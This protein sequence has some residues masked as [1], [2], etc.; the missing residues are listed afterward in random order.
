MKTSSGIATVPIS[1]VESIM[2]ATESGKEQALQAKAEM[3]RLKQ[4]I[5]GIETEMDR[6]NSTHTEIADEH[7]VLSTEQLLDY[8][9]EGNVV[10]VRQLIDGGA[11]T[12]VR[13]HNRRTPLMLAAFEGHNEVIGVL[14][15]AG[16]DFEARDVDGWGAL[17]YAV[18]GNRTETV[19]LLIDKGADISNPTVK[20]VAINKGGQDII[21]LLYQEGMNF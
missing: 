5:N 17:T 16:A 15:S 12:E 10:M 13:D 3:E 7:T 2:Y 6:F 21:E 1:R 20:T 8:A 9:K 11:D 18:Y 19:R 14:L 4:S